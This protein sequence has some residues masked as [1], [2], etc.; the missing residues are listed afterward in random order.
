MNIDRTHKENILY[1]EDK[2]IMLCANSSNLSNIS[3]EDMYNFVKEDLALAQYNQINEEEEE[4][5]EFDEDGFPISFPNNSEPVK[6]LGL[7]GQDIIAS[8][9]PIVDLIV[10]A[11]DA[12]K[13]NV[14]LECNDNNY[15]NVLAGALKQ[16]IQKIEELERKVEEL[17]CK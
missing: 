12:F 10:N 15:V 7:L 3:L 11:E 2:G 14:S 5:I 1:V 9:N 17:Q 8:E 16:A 4:E 13:R 6:E